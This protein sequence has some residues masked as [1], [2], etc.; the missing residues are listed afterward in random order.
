[1]NPRRLTRRALLLS[2]PVWFSACSLHRRDE[3]PLLMRLRQIQE[4]IGGRLGMHVLDTSTGR[5]IGLDDTALYAMASTFKP[6]LA[7]AVLSRVEQGS[8]EADQRVAVGER[9]MLAHAPVT[10]RYV[11]RGWMTVLELCGA[12]MTESDNPAA[13]LLLDLIGGPGELTRFMRALGDPVTRLDRKELELN[14]NLPGDPRD[15]TTPRAMVDTMRKLLTGAVLASPA[16]LR[17]IAW[18]KARG[19]DSTGYAQVCL[20]AGRR[21]TRRVPVPTEQSTTSRSRGRRIE[22]RSL[23]LST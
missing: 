9:D 16:R 6:L 18:R 7:A 21:A 12:I 17:L 8:L 4:H 19:P 13:N 15:T 20:R 2:S 11:E 1:M 3:E 10:S 14:S 23:S 5:R 22:R